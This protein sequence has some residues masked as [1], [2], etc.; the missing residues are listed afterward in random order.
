MK[1]QENQLMKVNELIDKVSLI[2]D[3]DNEWNQIATR[4]ASQNNVIEFHVFDKDKLAKIANDMKEI[5]RSI[6]AFGRKN[7][8]T[9]NKLLTLTM[10]SDTSPYKVLRQCLSQ[11]ESRRAA[12]KENR[13]KIIEK[14]IKIENDS[15]EIDLLSKKEQ[16]LKNRVPKDE[17]EKVDLELD[18]LSIHNQIE[19]KRVEVEK[20]IANLSDS[21]LYIEGALKDIASFQ[22]AYKQVCKNKNIPENWDEEDMEKAEIQAHIHMA[23]LLAYRDILVHHSLGMSSVEYLQQ[24][25]INPIQ[26]ASEITRYISIDKE[27]TYE[28]L[29]GFLDQMADKYKDNYKKVLKK[30]GIDNL[31]DKWCMYKEN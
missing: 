2:F 12:I 1:V 14:Q 31:Y 9:T 19:Q 18:L 8:Q 20:E 17:L 5:N 7:T 23:F 6:R 15:K 16:I 21:M 25:G 13:Y 3:K 4:T 30:L 29:E 22:S 26:G 28:S 24:L 27:Q 10:L 11:I